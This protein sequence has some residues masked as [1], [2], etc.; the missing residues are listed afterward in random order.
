MS[1]L[2]IIFILGC[3]FAGMRVHA[4]EQTIPLPAT[5][6]GQAVGDLNANVEDDQLRGLDL[7]PIRGSTFKA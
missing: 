2:L 3:V 6:N 5:L 7:S 1:K 4:V